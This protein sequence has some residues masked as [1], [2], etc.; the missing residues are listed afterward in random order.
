MIHLSGPNRLDATPTTATLTFN[1]TTPIALTLDTATAHN[2]WPLPPVK[3]HLHENATEQRIS[4]VDPDHGLIILLNSPE[5]MLIEGPDPEHPGHAIASQFTP[6]A[7]TAM[8]W[9]KLYKTLKG[10]TSQ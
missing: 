7:E 9:A 2:H 10:Q 6:D 3:P 8:Q 5:G 4:Y 1:T